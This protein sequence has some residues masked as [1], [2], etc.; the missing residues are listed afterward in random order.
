MTQ[1]A[2]ATAFAR[3]ENHYFLHG[4]W[5]EDG[6]LIAGVDAIRGIPAVIV[7]G[8]YDVCTPVMTAWD[9]H[10]AWPEADFVIV[11]DASHA[12]SEPGIARALRT[13]TDR[14]AAA[15]G[16]DANANADATASEAADG[17][18]AAATEP[19]DAFSDDAEPA[20]E[21]V[22]ARKRG[23]KA[24]APVEASADEGS[25]ATDRPVTDDGGDA[26]DHSVA[27]P[28]EPP[29]A[30]SPESEDEVVA[31]P[32]GSPA[33]EAPGT[34]AEPA[35]ESDEAPADDAEVWPPREEDSA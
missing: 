19:V 11:P 15:A 9:L 18:E 24:A 1:P 30:D 17:D 29:A 14:F 20:T 26:R 35:A 10:R 31:E 16:A 22:K 3:I 23:R 8:R 7:Q 21:P 32:D 28:V 34:E 25:D 33:D 27:E 6:Q 2:E 12:A 13:A 4:G 5:F